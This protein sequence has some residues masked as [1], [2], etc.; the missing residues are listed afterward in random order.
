MVW[1]SMA[2]RI[3]SF[4]QPIMRHIESVY[5]AFKPKPGRLNQH[6]PRELQLPARYYNFSR[7]GDSSAQLRIMI[8]FYLPISVVNI[9]EKTHRS[10][11]LER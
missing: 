11:I 10:I 1:I 4:S 6:P 8:L 2:D 5:R 3:R 7:S 9:F